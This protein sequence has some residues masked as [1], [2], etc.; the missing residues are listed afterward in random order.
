MSKKVLTEKE[1]EKLIRDGDPS[2]K[3]IG[4]RKTLN[5]SKLWNFFHYIIVND[6]RQQFVCC[7][8]C[9]GLLLH[10][11]L[12]GTNNLR[13]HVK[14]CPKKEK[15]SFAYQKTFRD[16]YSSLKPLPIPRKIKFSVIEACTEFCVLYA[17][18]F[19]VMRGDG[20]KNLAKTL[21]DAGRATSTT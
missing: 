7:N 9:K 5:S 15:S 10:S 1:L 2:I 8:A 14:S 3:F 11:S 4:R 17:H 12:N 19:D 18:A 16:F 13:T 6:D 20:L 21:F